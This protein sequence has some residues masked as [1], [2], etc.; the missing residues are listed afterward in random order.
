MQWQI[1]NG[2]FATLEACVDV[3]SSIWTSQEKYVLDL[4]SLLELYWLFSIWLE[5]RTSQVQNLR[6]TP[7]CAAD[8]ENLKN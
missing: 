8:F 7:H 5:K 4:E 6:R 1:L 3:L 2:I